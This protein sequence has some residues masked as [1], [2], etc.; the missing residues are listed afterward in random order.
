MHYS[1]SAQ[2]TR[3]MA[4][5]GVSERTICRKLEIM[6]GKFKQWLKG[7]KAQFRTVE[8]LAAIFKMS[9]N[10]FLGYVPEDEPKNEPVIHPCL[11]GYLED[12]DICTHHPASSVLECIVPHRDD[13][14]RYVQ[15]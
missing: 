14:G 7:R 3:H 11:A 15:S 13:A 4:A 5:T 12:G 10:D 8:I 6:P 9:A 2:L 1:I